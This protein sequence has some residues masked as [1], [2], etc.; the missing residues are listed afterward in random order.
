MARGVHRQEFGD[1][2]PAGEAELLRV[3]ATRARRRPTR[4]SAR[5][6]RRFTPEAAHA[7]L[8][9][10]ESKLYAADL[11]PL[12]RLP[13]AAGGV[14]PDDRHDRRADEGWRRRLPRRRAASSCSTAS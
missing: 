7:K 14:R 12:R 1:K 8:G 11:E 6:M 4:R 10:D 5:R 3:V 2:L 9:A 13:D